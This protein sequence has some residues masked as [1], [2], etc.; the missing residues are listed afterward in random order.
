MQFN[1][2]ERELNYK[3]K[4]SENSIE[5]TCP[6][7]TPSPL[8]QQMGSAMGIQPEQGAGQASWGNMRQSYLVFHGLLI[9]QLLFV[10][11]QGMPELD[12]SQ[13]RRLHAQPAMGILEGVGL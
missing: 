8:L 4:T 13:A 11:L 3:P 5:S 7:G 2:T 12:R 9:H 10:S 1:T 6:L